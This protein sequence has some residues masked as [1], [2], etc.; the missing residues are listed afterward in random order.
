MLFPCR[1]SDSGTLFVRREVGVAHAPDCVWHRLA[2]DA[3][4]SDPLTAITPRHIHQGSPFLLRH[5]RLPA[6]STGG[7][8]PGIRLDRRRRCHG[9]PRCCSGCSPAPASMSSVPTKSAPGQADAPVPPT[10]KRTTNGCAP[11]TATRSATGSR[12]GICCAPGS[13]LSVPTFNAS[14]GSAPASR[15]GMRPQG[16]FWGVVDD[17]AVDHDTTK[18]T[19]TY[20]P[21]NDRRHVA[22]EL[23]VAV[24]IP[25]RSPT[26][27][28]WLLAALGVPGDDPS[29]PFRALDAYAHPVYS[30]SL[31][32]PVDSDSERITA[33]VLL[34]QLAW[35]Q[36][37]CGLRVRLHKPWATFTLPDGDVAPPPDFLLTSPG[38]VTVAVETMGALDDPDYVVRKQ[39]SHDL[40]RRI[41]GVADIVEHDPTLIGNVTQLRRA[42]N[43]RILPGTHADAT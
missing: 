41:P 35:W 33:A 20:G 39:R 29:A 13:P 26:G 12:A 4:P 43:A 22:G 8:A 31:L 23:P 3:E 9:S 38:H 40:M 34:D 16:L 11:S 30:R 32:L 5:P 36:H 24:R 6:A 27:P 25:G 19:Y 14:T 2:V 37:R 28:F 17:L 7:H 18:V 10:R 15:P 21:R 42:L 1:R